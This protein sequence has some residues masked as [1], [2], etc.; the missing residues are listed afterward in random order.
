MKYYLPLLL[1]LLF[2]KSSTAQ[3][4]TLRVMTYNT[5]YY[6]NGCQG[7]ND[8][9]H[10]YFK[11]IVGHTNPDV[12][13]LVKTASP[14]LTPDDP[15]GSAPYGFVDSILRFAL[16][17]AFPGRYACCPITNSAMTNNVVML[18]Y[19]TRKLGFVSLVCSYVN[20]TDF[21]T[22]KLYYKDPNLERTHD[23]T[24]LYFTLNHDKSGDEFEKVRLNQI[25]GCMGLVK[26]HFKQFPNYINLGDFNSRGADERFY[27][28]L[29]KNPDSNFCLYDPPFF[30]DRKLKYPAHWDHEGEYSAYFTTS[31]RESAVVPN[32]CGTGGGG[33]NWYDH[34]FIS[35]WVMEN[36]NYVRYI[37]NSYRTIG[38]DGQRFRVSAINKNA[39]V[40]S[41]AP[42]NVVYALYQMSNKYPVMIDLAVTQN[43]TGT[44][45]ADPEIPVDAFVQKEEVS[46]DSV[47]TDEL[48]IHFSPSFVGQEVEVVATDAAGDKVFKKKFII[49]RAEMSFR[50]KE[51]PGTY[52]VKISGKH[53]LIFSTTVRRQ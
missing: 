29:T 32:A 5:L 19:D 48:K 37:P 1:T 2:A 40:N 42:E 31:T 27:Q 23:T 25:S 9:Y 53:N 21:N 22:Y 50:F 8:R 28:L 49:R 26:Q 4:D 3:T 30:P 44:S 24:F 7:P 39:H 20:I 38:N 10:G 35:R 13:S 36:T 15:Y 14:K 51:A 41:S 11:T 45:P 33:K 17:A 18:F 43:T 12:I 46:I 6:G 52:T 16:N 34:I 47:V